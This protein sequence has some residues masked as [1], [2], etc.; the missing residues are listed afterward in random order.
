[1]I[2]HTVRWRITSAILLTVLAAIGLL[3]AYLSRWTD[4]YYVSAVRSNLQAESRLVSRLSAPL[5]SGDPKPID[6]LAHNAGRDLNCR[7][8]II[9]PDGVV[10]GDSH[11]NRGTM[12]LHNSRPEFRSAITNGS[13]WA[14]RYSK[15]LRTR[16]LYVASRIG[17]AERPLGVA[18][19]SESL[20][21][22]DQA[23][24]RIHHVFFFAT[25][26]TF[27]IV[28]IVGARVAEKITGPIQDMSV[29]ARRLARGELGS[30][31]EI[32]SRARGEIEELAATL[33][34]AANELRR[35]MSELTDE[36]SKLQTILDKTDDGIMVVD[37]ESRVQM[38]NP[39][40]SR[41]LGMPRS[42]IVGKTIIESTLS[43]DFSSLLDRVL[44][45]SSPASLEI[46]LTQP[47]QTYMNVY[48]T[49]IEVSLRTDG[50]V[51]VIHDVT[52]SKRTDAMRRD[53]VANVSHELRTPLASIRAM[54]ETI[55]IRGRKDPQ[56]AEDFAK[57][58]VTEADRLTAMSDDLLDL[59]KI[60]AGRR[61][62][63]AQAF[64]LS[65]VSS[66]IVAE[67]QPRAEKKGISIH[68]EIPDGLQVNADRD[69]VRQILSNLIDN[70][71][72]Y[73]KQGEVKVTAE[74]ENGRVAV[75]VSDTGIGIPVSDLP[76]I[77]ERFYRVD[78]A[79]S[80]ESGGTG[81]GLS[82]VKHLVEAHGGK[83]TVKSSPD[84]GT[85]F[86][87]TLPQG[88]G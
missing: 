82:I 80:R 23:R 10:L 87:F 76:R 38:V 31:A 88:R 30:A 50:A 4:Q 26:L 32:P 7:V 11:H 57:T 79:R 73:T 74:A 37:S 25:L 6:A 85:S 14:I 15:T 29:V 61:V 52:S 5:M 35:M 70:A 36:K 44:R 62:I 55:V 22:V 64:T 2:F 16:M 71:V 45:T 3:A 84:S 48:I 18:R 83:V 34:V 60:E 33:N 17:S 63:H 27:V 65:E 75:C 40:A 54:A 69:A 8:T 47:T 20:A 1:M 12:D 43:H 49:P 56:S 51:I 59:A 28:G 21:Q 46:E 67:M 66:E 13:G 53:F 78:K 68:T 39:A 58:I 41:L 77:F 81:L 19:L 9:G 42:Q 86:I 72:K 24:A